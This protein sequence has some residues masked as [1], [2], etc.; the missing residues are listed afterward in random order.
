[1][2]TPFPKKDVVNVAVTGAA[3]Q[4]GYAIAPIIARGLMLGAGQKIALHLLDL[5]VAQNAL[6]GLKMEL[7]DCA[8]A[9]LD[10]VVLTTDPEVAFAGCDIAILCGAFPRKPGMERKDLLQINAKIFKAQGAVLKAVAAPHCRVVVVGNPANTN[11]LLLALAADGGLDARNISALTRLDHNRAM[12]IAGAKVGAAVKNV[13]IWG[14]HSGTQVPDVNNAV[15]ADGKR[16]RDVADNN[17][18]FDD[19]FIAQVQQRG[20]AVMK[21]RGFSSALSAAKATVDHVHDW[22]VGTPDDGTFVSMGVW[23]N[24]NSYGVPD[25]LVYSF[26]V[27]CKQGVWTIVDGVTVSPAVKA[28]QEATTA[29]LVDERAQA[30]AAE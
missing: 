17:S 26:P 20:A 29:E 14:N 11:A 18:F 6:E 1:M 10:K 30:T 12:G 5:E 27:K 7:D 24:G 13:I 21:L 16:V 4:I 3:G 23:S 2:S 28:L 9:A 22:I 8:F 25:G 19:E 15:T